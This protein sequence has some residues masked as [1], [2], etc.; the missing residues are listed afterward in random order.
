MII[1]WEEIRHTHYMKELWPIY[2]LAFSCKERSIAGDGLKTAQGCLYA[3]FPQK[4]S[5]S[6]SLFLVIHCHYRRFTKHREY[7]CSKM[8]TVNLLVFFMLQLILCYG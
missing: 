1:S 7:P 6:V 8:V 2:L 5:F 4:M 3:V